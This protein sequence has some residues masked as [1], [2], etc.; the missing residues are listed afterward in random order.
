[1]SG[2]STFVA[3]AVVAASIS[4][5]TIWL[6]LRFADRG[7]AQPGH[8]SLHMR[9]TPHGGGLGIVAAALLCGAW[10]GA[11]TGWLVP[12]FVLAAVS[13]ADDWLDLPFWLR[14]GIHLAAAASVVA[15]HGGLSVPVVVMQIILIA[16]STNAYNFMDGADGL[17]GSMSTVGFAAYAVGLAAAG[18]A[19]LAALCAAMAGAAAG[20]LVFNWHPA[21]IFMGDVGSIPSGFL[22]GGLGWYGYAA[23]AWPAWFAPMVF[24]P[25]LFDATVTLV[26]R[27]LRG[28]RVWQA[29]R[30]HYY[31]RMVRGAYAHD[32]MCRR[33][34]AVMLAGASLAVLLLFLDSAGWFGAV[35]WGLTLVALGR[36][37]DLRWNR[38]LE[39]ESAK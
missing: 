10:A 2:P 32:A 26:R 9:P 24:A 7:L 18:E 22:A 12:F 6:R 4:A 8:R 5:A 20:F 29:H 21:R 11:G 28:E 34:L 33:W 13:W 17:A 16:W 39:T 27:V 30:D 14:L 31:Q 37:I 36:R 38:H 15:I 19:A 23:G 1:V 25:F 35:V 3:V